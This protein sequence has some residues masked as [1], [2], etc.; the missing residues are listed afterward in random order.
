VEEERPII[1]ENVL[2]HIIYDGQCSHCEARG[3]FCV[4]PSREAATGV[5][6]TIESQLA[7]QD[8][9]IMTEGFCLHCVINECACIRDPAV[10]TR[11][12]AKALNTARQALAQRAAAM[13]EIVA[14][15]VT[16]SNPLVTRLDNESQPASRAGPTVTV[17]A[18]ST[19]S[20]RSEGHQIEEAQ[21]ISAVPTA[22]QADR[23]GTPFPSTALAGPPPEGFHHYP[24][25]PLYIH[26]SAYYEDDGDVY[27]VAFENGYAHAQ[28]VAVAQILGSATV[29]G[30]SSNNANSIELSD[31]QPHNGT[32]VAPAAAAGV[33]PATVGSIFGV[34][35][36]GTHGSGEVGSVHSLSSLS[37][38]RSYAASLHFTR[39]QAAHIEQEHR[40]GHA[41]TAA[42]SVGDNDDA[43]AAADVEGMID[44]PSHHRRAFLYIHIG[45]V[46]CALVAF[47]VIV[48]VSHTRFAQQ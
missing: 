10:G 2:D 20:S 24:I 41:F 37:R 34:V 23:P 19:S 31:M 43:A 44:N 25:H 13:P 12:A 3:C 35:A 32:A 11:H 48:V 5:S 42:P 4:V 40:R 47:T 39:E 6:L 16:F 33:A 15:R 9:S 1:V 28:A 18:L 8:N 14:P 22:I 21:T 26:N 36:N 7:K 30:N 38:A 46:V 17:T 29:D 27:T 45:I